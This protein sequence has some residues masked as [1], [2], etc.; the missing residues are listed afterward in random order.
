M[1]EQTFKTLEAELGLQ[2]APM[3]EAMGISEVSVKRY[4]TGAQAIPA[5]IAKL[6]VAL[7]A[8]RATKK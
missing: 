6:T 2:H 1:D 4:A 8:L 5:H 7:R 3:A